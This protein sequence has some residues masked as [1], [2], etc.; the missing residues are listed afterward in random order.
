MPRRENYWAPSETLRSCEGTG[1]AHQLAKIGSSMTS[2]K[3]VGTVSPNV[4]FPEAGY[5]VYH[6]HI[7]TYTSV[8]G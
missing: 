1:V 4:P 2:E 6:I 3:D 8:V 7:I 5:D